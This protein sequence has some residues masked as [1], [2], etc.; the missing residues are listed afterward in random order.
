GR[1]GGGPPIWSRRAACES[2]KTRRFLPAAPPPPAAALPPP[3]AGRTGLLE[4]DD[5]GAGGLTG[6]PAPPAGLASPCGAAAFWACGCWAGAVGLRARR[7]A[8]DCFG[9]RGHA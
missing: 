7:A 3:P 9:P 1:C 4:V 5:F 2:I 6:A 8:R